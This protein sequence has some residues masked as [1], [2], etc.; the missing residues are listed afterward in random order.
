MNVFLFAEIFWVGTRLVGAGFSRRG[1]R[2]DASR[3]LEF[4]H[5]DVCSPRKSELMSPILHFARSIVTQT[6]RE[7][8]QGRPKLPS[9]AK[10]G[11]LRPVRK[12]REATLAAQTG[13]ERKRDSA[14]HQ[15][16]LVPA[17]DYWKLHEPPRPRLSK[18]R[19]YLLD[20]AATP[21]WPRRGAAAFSTHTPKMAKLQA[22]ALAGAYRF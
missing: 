11:C 13:A 15:A 21:P 7:Y 8:C 3:P 10:E 4:G 20:G 2:E 9:L 22:P 14:Q 12:C 17:T 19:G 6:K 1:V 18:E 16:W 5:F